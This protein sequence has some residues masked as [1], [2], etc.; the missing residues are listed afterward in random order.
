M[1][2]EKSLMCSK[3]L[4][5]SSRSNILF[6]Y[7]HL[8]IPPYYSTNKRSHYNAKVSIILIY[9]SK[10]YW[11]M[12]I[13]HPEEFSK[14]FE[15]LRFS[16][17]RFRLKSSWVLTPHGDVVEYHCFTE[18]CCYLHPEDGDFRNEDATT[19]IPRN[20]FCL[21]QGMWFADFRK[22]DILIIAELYQMLF[23]C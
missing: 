5:P 7:C 16:G 1:T 15:G 23:S 22:L 18:L 12:I 2:S 21:W 3:C 4:H 11:H 20:L 8:N 10:K 6:L 9:Y 19:W 17:W 13:P 14:K